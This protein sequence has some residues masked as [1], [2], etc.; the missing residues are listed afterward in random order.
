M[1]VI[2]GIAKCTDRAAVVLCCVYIRYHF[3]FGHDIFRCHSFHTVFSFR[4]FIFEM[5][6]HEDSLPRT[7]FA[8][9]DSLSAVHLGDDGVD[10]HSGLFL[11]DIGSGLLCNSLLGKQIFQKVPIFRVQLF[12]YV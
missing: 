7:I 9:W 4:A 6:L 5:P 3:N 1:S 11:E 2:F 12:F 8:P 10:L